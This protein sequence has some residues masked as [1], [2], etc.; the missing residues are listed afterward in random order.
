[1]SAIGEVLKFLGRR[2]APG[3]AAGAVTGA[4]TSDEDP[5]SAAVT[6]AITGGGISSAL[7]ATKA[8]P[9]IAR[10]L[11]VP[12]LGTKGRAARMVGE[13]MKADEIT[14]DMLRGY[15][16]EGRPGVSPLFLAPPKGGSSNLFARAEDAALSPGP[17]RNTAQ[18]F[19][20]DFADTQ[21]PR[22]MGDVKA[23]LGH[24]P[25]AFKTVQALQ[26]LRQV[27]AA[28]L[29]DKAYEVKGIHDEEMNDLLNRAEKLG[30]FGRM[31]TIATADP[32]WK[33]GMPKQIT[34]EDGS[35]V[36]RFDTQHADLIKRGLDSMIQS[37]TDDVTGKM[38]EEGRAIGKLKRSILKRIDDINPD[39]AKAR[40]AYAGPSASIDAV[41]S[42]KKLLSSNPSDMDE[43]L[44]DFDHLPAGAKDFYRLGVVQ[45]IKD[46]VAS[47]V[48]GT[49]VAKK[50]FS[51]RHMRDKL[52]H[53]FPDAASYDK[54]EKNMLNEIKI[55]D[56]K[57]AILGN[58]ATARRL[59]EH[60]NAMGVDT[61]MVGDVAHL[62]AGNPLPIITR[63]AR[64][65]GRLKNVLDPATTK[66][67]A[68]ML[69]E[70][71]PAKQQAAIDLI[72]KARTRQ[73]A[74]HVGTVALSAGAGAAAGAGAGREYG[75][76]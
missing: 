31:E 59:I 62:A 72:E 66:A 57:N 44:D 52:Q 70:T 3:A 37:H 21:E 54:F 1:M 53:V 64:H 14:P 8:I 24:D 6:G 12:M 18:K 69:Y 65:W 46:R 10:A 60:A 15:A 30:A 17:A 33:A 49:D 48:E 67:M 41:N 63:L 47:G 61:D 25:D 5:Y 71:D 56:A 50:F 23:G 16:A 22:V 68:D 75:G 36:Y 73:K 20:T 13:A 38:D 45:G 51:N 32:E 29:Y 42:G 27:E 35:K 39:F 9:M 76:E 28:P 58:S 43:L 34:L 7:A 11:R 74:M 55:R 4:I 2:T 40:A 19:F 26:K